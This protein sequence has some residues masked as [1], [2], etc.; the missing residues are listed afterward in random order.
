MSPA[1][2]AVLDSGHDDEPQ[3]DNHELASD[4]KD[5]FKEELEPLLELDR[6]SLFLGSG[7]TGSGNGQNAGTN[8]PREVRRVLAGRLWNYLDSLHGVA[9]GSTRTRVLEIADKGTREFEFRSLSVPQGKKE[10]KP[11]PTMYVGD[12]AVVSDTSDPVSVLEALAGFFETSRERPH[13]GTARFVA[14]KI[15]VFLTNP[16]LCVQLNHALR[17]IVADDLDG[18]EVEILDKGAL[19]KETSVD[20]D[21]VAMSEEESTIKALITAGKRSMEWVRTELK[22]AEV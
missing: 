5:H 3:L 21:E 17:R 19:D 2:A 1:V 15:C 7:E 6:L 18:E 13:V 22:L 8:F 4:V 11:T 16:G 14:G 12:R 10:R 20:E 9:P